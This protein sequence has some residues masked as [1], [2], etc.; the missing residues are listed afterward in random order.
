MSLLHFDYISQMRKSTMAGH[1]SSGSMARLLGSRLF[2][3]L[4]ELENLHSW[5][6]DTHHQNDMIRCLLS[7][8]SS[9]GW[10]RYPK[11]AV[12]PP[13]CYDPHIHTIHTCKQGWL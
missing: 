2:L 6:Q 9:T 11:F 4:L 7:M 13:S 1:P 3:G 10:N 8:T 12:P 5:R